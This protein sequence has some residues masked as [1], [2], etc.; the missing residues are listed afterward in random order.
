[1]V[2]MKADSA[3]PHTRKIFAILLAIIITT[4][5][6]IAAAFGTDPKP[7]SGP[8]S[9]AAHDGNHNNKPDTVI[10]P[11]GTEGYALVFGDASREDQV[12]VEVYED[13]QCPYC[14]DLSRFT[15]EPFATFLQQGDLVLKVYPVAFLDEASTTRYSTRAANAVA[16]V[17]DVAGPIAAYQYLGILYQN[18]PAE[19]TNG[20]TDQKLLEYAA[21]VGSDPE[22][23]EQRMRDRVFVDWV[24]EGSE[25]AFNEGIE[26]TPTVFVDGE[27]ISDP[28]TEL[29]PVFDRFTVNPGN[30]PSPS[31]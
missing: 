12:T 15:S 10:A 11:Y 17:Y 25:K 4:G 6:V 19:G 7:A 20:L 1:M 24:T 13:L 23:T 18:Q 5:V 9:T 2:D 28:Y 14:R 8:D 27:N 31:P 21:S 26:G 29:P 16:A 30:T 22:E 3:N